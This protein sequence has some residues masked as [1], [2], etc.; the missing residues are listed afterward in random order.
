MTCA[1]TS[2]SEVGSS[3]RPRRRS[4]RRRRRS[5]TACTAAAKAAS[6]A[7]AGESGSIDPSYPFEDRYDLI[8][9]ER[10][11]SPPPSREGPP[12]PSSASPVLEHT[13]PPAAA[14]DATDRRTGGSGA[15]IGTLALLTAIAPLA[16]D[17]ALPAFPATATDLGVSASAVQ[18]T[19]TAFMI[20][21]ALG[22]LVIGP[23][24]DQ[25]GRR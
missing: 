5:T 18:L 2:S 12:V 19:L 24:S 13:A 8:P 16:T 9:I 23:L 11:R 7:G 15:L 10:R 6:S 20:G 3:S 21:L 25:W 17:L 14:P 4:P 1:R 22:Q